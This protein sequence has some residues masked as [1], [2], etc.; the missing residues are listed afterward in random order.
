MAQQVLI[1]LEDDLDGGEAAETVTFAL[2]GVSYE[3]DLSDAHAADL[4]EEL[5]S[6]VAAARRIGGRKVH[7]SSASPSTG[8]RERTQAIREWARNQGIEVSDR[9]RISASVAAQYDEAQ[10]A[11]AEEPRAPRKRATRKKATAK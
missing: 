10:S 1:R 9:G 6:Y 7:G 4:R 5:A 11:P 3:I 8:D 2:D